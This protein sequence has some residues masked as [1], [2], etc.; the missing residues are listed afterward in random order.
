MVGFANVERSVVGVYFDCA[1]ELFDLSSE[2]ATFFGTEP[3]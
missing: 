3:A 2:A 1:D